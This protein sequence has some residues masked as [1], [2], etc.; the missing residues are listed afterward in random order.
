MCFICHPYQP[1]YTDYQ[2][3]TIRVCDSLL[4]EYYGNDDLMAATD[5]FS[6]CGGWT[7]ADSTLEPVDSND[8]NKGFVLNSSDPVLVIPKGTFKTAED[9][10]SNW[11]QASIPFMDGFRIQNVPDVIDG[12][13]SECYKSATSLL[14]QT[15]IAALLAASSLALFA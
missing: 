5:K 8:P 13:A 1:R 4:R 15:T 11:D 2:Y 9:F 12:V 7:T 10:Y 14:A 3:K 6:K